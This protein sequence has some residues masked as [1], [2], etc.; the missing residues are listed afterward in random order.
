MGRKNDTLSSLQGICLALERAGVPRDRPFDYALWK[1]AVRLGTGT[2]AAQTVSNYTTAAKELGLIEVRG[3]TR[4][5][6][7]A[8]KGILGQ[9]FEAP[10]EGAAA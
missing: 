1:S 5:R 9:D 6:T 10:V 4:I 3:S 7:V 8:L 2:T